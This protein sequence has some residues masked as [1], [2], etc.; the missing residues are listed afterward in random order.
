MLHYIG[1]W[2]IKNLKSSFSITY[3][4][5]WNPMGL[6]SKLCSNTINANGTGLEGSNHKNLLDILT[7]WNL[8][9]ET[10]IFILQ[11]IKNV[12]FLCFMH[13]NVETQKT[14]NGESMNDSDSDKTGINHAVITFGPKCD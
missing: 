10:E 2:A 13:S 4:S 5:W 3:T 14:D 12:L 9:F 7:N 8:N 11:M 6:G 1:D